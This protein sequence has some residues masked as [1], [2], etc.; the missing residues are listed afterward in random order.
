MRDARSQDMERYRRAVNDALQQLEWC[1]GY[2]YGIR[3]RRLSRALARNREQIRQ[4]LMRRSEPA[5]PGQ[6]DD[7]A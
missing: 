2:L 6:P 3:R 1:I 5:Q 4:T 7:E